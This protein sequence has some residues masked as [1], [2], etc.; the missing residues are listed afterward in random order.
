MKKFSNN[1][2]ELL[3]NMIYIIKYDYMQ[4]ILL[5]WIIIYYFT[6]KQTLLEIKAQMLNSI[7]SINNVLHLC[8]CK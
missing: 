6:C 1:D 3:L 8:D 7:D 5:L 4:N 2:Y